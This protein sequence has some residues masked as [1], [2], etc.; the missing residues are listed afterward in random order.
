MDFIFKLGMLKSVFVA[1]LSDLK[2]DKVS[3][4]RI[5]SLHE[6]LAWVRD[7]VVLEQGCS[8]GPGWAEISC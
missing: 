2:K 1:M 3:L 8:I 4:R 6:N 5:L 7:S